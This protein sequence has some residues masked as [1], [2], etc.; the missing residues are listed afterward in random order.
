MAKSV[1]GS[2]KNKLY[3]FRISDEIHADLAEIKAKTAQVGIRY[4]LSEVLESALQRE[5]KA[6]RKAIQEKE[7]GWEPGQG[8]LAL[9]D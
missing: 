8:N 6:L 5:I 1:Q 2:V 3:S 4:N 9:E 7:P